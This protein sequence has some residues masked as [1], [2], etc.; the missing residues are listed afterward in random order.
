MPRA[1]L[2]K[3]RK[4]DGSVEEEEMMEQ[5][6]SSES[7]G[8]AFTIVKPKH[9]KPIVEGKKK[10]SVFTITSYFNLR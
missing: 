3:N 4:E 2:V 8:S 10:L 1:F 5:D 7:S 9:P 6:M